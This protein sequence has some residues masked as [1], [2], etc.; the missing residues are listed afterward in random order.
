VRRRAV[1]PS[2]HKRYLS[3]MVDK[4]FCNC[5]ERLV[6]KLETYALSGE[7]VNMEARFS[8]MTLDVIGPLFNYTPINFRSLPYISVSGSK[9]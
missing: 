1:V 5:A 6:E 2:L 8:Q 7:P 3:V 4:V 9:H